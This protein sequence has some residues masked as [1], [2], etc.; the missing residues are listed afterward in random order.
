MPNI[1]S[2]I[3]SQFAERRGVEP[4]VLFYIEPRNRATGTREALGLWNGTDDR[5]FVVDGAVRSF[6]G[7][8]EALG[9]APIRSVTGLEVVYHTVELPPFTDAVRLMLEQYDAHLAPVRIYSLALNIDTMQ[10]LSAPIRFVKGTLQ[11]VSKSVP[12]A[13]GRGANT[14]LKI[15]SNTRRL[16]VGLPIYRSQGALAQR[17][18][19]DLGREHIAVALDWIVPWGEA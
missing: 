16:T 7:I 9:I 3:Q 11:E 14:T 15:A 10:P 17:D 18:A 1:D 2:I 12:A 19:S 13:G 8:G 6:L 5:D 4:R